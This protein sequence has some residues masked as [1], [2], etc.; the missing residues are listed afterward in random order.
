MYNLSVLAQLAAMATKNNQREQQLAI[1]SMKDLF[2]NNLLPDRA[3]L[4]FY[5]HPDEV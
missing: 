5:D 2:I 4:F 1:E 3:L